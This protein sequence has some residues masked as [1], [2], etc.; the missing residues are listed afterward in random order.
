MVLP[1]GCA[2]SLQEISPNDKEN[3]QALM[4]EVK[5][6]SKSYGGTK[7]LKGIDLCVEPGKISVLIGPSGSGKTTLL[8]VLA[9]LETPE[10]GTVSV[11]GAT[12]KFPLAKDV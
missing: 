5:Q 9:L 2:G 8:K 4:L 3:D 7:V 6:V 1:C 10:S 12:Y 11:D